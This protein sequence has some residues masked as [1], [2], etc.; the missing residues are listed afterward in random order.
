MMG[1]G[2]QKQ[3]SQRFLTPRK[4]K[5]DTSISPNIVT[6]P[7]TSISPNIVT[8]LIFK[9]P[10]VPD[11]PIHEKMSKKLSYKRKKSNVSD[12][13]HRSYKPQNSARSSGHSKRSHRSG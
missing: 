9:A 8:G 4:K 10:I 12:R 6:G 5:S 13:S 2:P 1:V 3:K 7:D 11:V